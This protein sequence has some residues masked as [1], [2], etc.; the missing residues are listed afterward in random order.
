MAIDPGKWGENGK[1]ISSEVKKGSHILF[2]EY[3][4]SEMKIEGAGHIIMKENDIPGIM[5]R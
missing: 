2:Y 3:A 1:R 5:E 4:G